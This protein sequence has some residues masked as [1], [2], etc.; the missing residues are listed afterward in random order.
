M[1]IQLALKE[2]TIYGLG[3]TI[4]KS[5]HF[6]GSLPGFVSY[7]NHLLTVWSSERYQLYLA[8]VSWT[9][10]ENDNDIKLTGLLWELNKLI[11]KKFF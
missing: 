10:N 11:Y 8:S 5:V 4:V 6:W 9:V 7:F 1:D 2:K 3:S